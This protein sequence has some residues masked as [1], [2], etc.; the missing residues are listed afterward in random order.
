MKYGTTDII[1]DATAVEFSGVKPAPK[2]FPENYF[3]TYFIITD[4][5]LRT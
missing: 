3:F 4:H 2:A 5:V 1:R